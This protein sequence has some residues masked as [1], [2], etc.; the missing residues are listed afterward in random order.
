CAELRHE[1][2]RRHALGGAGARS[3]QARPGA[4]R[5]R[6]GARRAGAQRSAMTWHERVARR[7]EWY[8]GVRVELGVSEYLLQRFS[9]QRCAALGLAD[10]EAYADLLESE[11]MPARELAL[12][13]NAVTTG[14]TSF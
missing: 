4:R 8:C 11:P 14:Q 7:C 2:R 6:A 9:R 12:L 13:A 1:C 10:E 5:G 3:R